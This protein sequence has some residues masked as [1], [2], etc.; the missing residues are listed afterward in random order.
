M[1][2]AEHTF[3]SHLVM[4]GVPMTAVQMLMGHSV[5]TTTMKYAHLAPS[6]LRS[7]IDMLNPRTMAGVDF[8]QPVGNH[9]L[10]TQ[11]KALVKK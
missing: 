4:R 5:I 3:A 11:K 1:A 2:C 6:T 9:W 7:A 8:G 10:E